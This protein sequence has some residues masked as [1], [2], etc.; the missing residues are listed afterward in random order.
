MRITLPSGVQVKITPSGISFAR[1]VPANPVATDNIFTAA[2]DVPVGTG[3]SAA[4][5]RPLQA[6]WNA[7]GNLGETPTVAFTAS[8]R[9]LGTVNLSIS[10]FA[11]TDPG[12]AS[13]FYL[14]LTKSADAT[15]RTIAWHADTGL[16]HAA[17][18]ADESPLTTMGTT[19]GR[20]YMIVLHRLDA[21]NRWFAAKVPGG[22]LA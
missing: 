10:S 14:L 11:L 4:G 13:V 1:R 15:E 9:Q 21:A 22:A 19:T 16:D 6:G 12:Y 2:G 7:N 3:A 8:I 5:V 20:R 18:W 17:N